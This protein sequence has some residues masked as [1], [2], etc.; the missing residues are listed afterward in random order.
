MMTL[1][2]NSKLAALPVLAICVAAC[3]PTPASEEPDSLG[4]VMWDSSELQ[5]RNETLGALIGPDG[6]ARETLAEYGNPSGAHRFRFIRRDSD[7]PPERHDAIDDVVYIQSGSGTCLL[8]TS[9][10]PRD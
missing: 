5:Q 9:P 3:G 7:G 1:I 6:S 4:F 8:Y 10:S 2:R